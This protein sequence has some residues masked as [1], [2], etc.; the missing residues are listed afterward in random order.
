MILLSSFK[1][2]SFWS[3]LSFKVSIFS[4]RKFVQNKDCTMSISQRISLT[5]QFQCIVFF[6]KTNIATNIKTYPSP[7]NYIK[8]I[9]KELCDIVL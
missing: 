9:V 7:K 5:E 3:F 1:S 6:L 4:L 2:P 8:T